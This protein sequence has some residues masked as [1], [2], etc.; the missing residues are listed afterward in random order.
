MM[1]EKLSLQQKKIFNKVFFS[2]TAFTGASY[3]FFRFNLIFGS[4]K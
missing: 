3:S 4:L 2:K 1:K